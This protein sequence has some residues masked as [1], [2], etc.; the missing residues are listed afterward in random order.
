MPVKSVIIIGGG[1]AGLTCALHLSRFSIDVTIV[2]KDSFPRHKVC[3]EYISNEVLPYLRSLGVDPF[4]LGAKKIDRFELSSVRGS[5]LRAKLPLGGFSLSRYTLDNY[6]YMLAMD[7]GVRYIHDTVKDVN[8]KQ[9]HFSVKCKNSEDLK[10]L[11]VIGAFGKRSNLDQK[12]QRVFMKSKAPYLAVK[13][14][15]TGDYP[16]DLVG[17]HHFYGGYCGV[18]QVEGGA[19]NI[20]Y[21]AEYEEF[22]KKGDLYSFQKN[23]LEKNKTLK[24]IFDSSQMIFD[25]QLSI[26]QINF[27]AKPLVENHIIMCGDSAGMIHPL[28]GNGMSMAIQSAK[29]LSQLLIAYFDGELSRAEVESEYG[30]EWNKRFRMRLTSGRWLSRFFSLKGLSLGLMTGLKRFPGVLQHII[31][32]THGKITEPV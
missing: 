16:P 32:M 5:S 1:L 19:L 31:R 6:M 24:R 25:K 30:R 8:F 14:H 12:L 28:C 7:A 22:K 11:F 17:L 15:Y 13:A 20:C 10:S 21:I 29:M 4:D 27:D 26:S 3:G 23:V 9:D 2:E 18:S